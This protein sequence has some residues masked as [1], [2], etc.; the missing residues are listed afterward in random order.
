MIL[1]RPSHRSFTETSCAVFIAMLVAISVSAQSPAIADTYFN[2][3]N[4]SEYVVLNADGTLN[5]HVQDGEDHSG[6]Y[7]VDG[8]VLT[9]RVGFIPF[10]AKLVNGTIVNLMHKTWAKDPQPVPAP[11]ATSSTEA[12]AVGAAPSTAQQNAS[13]EVLTN[14]KIIEMLRAKLPE[15]VVIAKI[16]SSRSQFD[17]SSEA[18]IAL[19]KAGASD[20]VLSA[21]LGSEA[22]ANGPRPAAA[23][24]SGSTAQSA[25]NGTPS[26]LEKS[27]DFI[28]S[29]IAKWVGNYMRRNDV[30]AEG[31]MTHIMF[32]HPPACQYDGE[33]RR[34]VMLKAVT[35][36][37]KGAFNQELKYW[38]VQAVTSGAY[39]GF[40]GGRPTIECT[41]R[42]TPI[43]FH[44][45]KND[46]GDWTAVT[47][48]SF[49]GAWVR[50]CTPK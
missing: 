2:R 49:G 37:R 44:V 23:S 28:I 21:I 10:K 48:Y 36:V 30:T 38:P 22:A 32:N 50:S 13:G 16:R 12:G 4:R 46:Y 45:L 15:S 11:P 5:W 39:T 9:V 42:T 34:I 14:G 19:R 43:D 41:F 27:S 47:D 33:D 25:G 3:D 6:K 26:N 20:N 17:T 31:D 35:V 7:K 40:L 18:L 29:S 1:A 8:D 24:S